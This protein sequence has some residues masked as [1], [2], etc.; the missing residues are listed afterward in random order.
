MTYQEQIEHIEQQARVETKKILANDGGLYQTHKDLAVK[1]GLGE[2]HFESIIFYEGDKVIKVKNPFAQCRVTLNPINEAIYQHIIHNIY[3]PETNYRLVGLTEIN[4]TLRVV[5]E[6]D[7]VEK[8][9]NCTEEE[10]GAYIRGKGFE[11]DKW[12]YENDELKVVDS[13]PSNAIVGTDDRLYVIDP[14]FQMKMKAVDIIA[15]HLDNEHVLR[16]VR[17]LAP[18]CSELNELIQ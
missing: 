8:K 17:T 7:K 16:E 2:Y 4:G 9:R 6:Q 15:R 5:L 14:M 12:I 13:Y 3:F 10:I 11:I 18:I 1:Y